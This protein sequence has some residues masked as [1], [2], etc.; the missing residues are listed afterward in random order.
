MLSEEAQQNILKDFPNIKL[1]YENITHKKV[2]KYD[3]YLAIPCGKKC[4]A[5]FTIFDNKNVCFVMEISDRK[6]ILNIKIYNCVFNDNLSFGTILYGTQ[7]NTQGTHFFTIEDIFLYKG[8][9]VSNKNWLNKFTY[10]G[11]LFKGDIKQIAYTKNCLVFGLPLIENNIKELDKKINQLK[12]KIFC[13]NLKNFNNTNYSDIVLY[14]NINTLLL[15]YGF[16]EITNKNKKT[17][18]GFVFELRPDIQND[19]YHLYCYNDEKNTELV[20][21][22]IA[23]VPDFKTSVM[24]NS[25]LRNIKE[26]TNLDLL[27]ESDSEEEFENTNLNKFVYLDKKVRVICL[28]NYKFK[29]WYPIKIVETKDELTNL[30]ALKYY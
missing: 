19:I 9:D 25:L 6:A 1:S 23:L 27:E 21:Y 20:N 10:I 26:N 13:I 3:I 18:K 11:N 29:K 12:Y 16:N 8:M 14:K 7:F 2:Y 15:T 22:G 24:L 30:H 4:F 17:K 5:W 28:Y